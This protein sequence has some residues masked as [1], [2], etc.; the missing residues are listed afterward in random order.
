MF[1]N[2]FGRLFKKRKERQQREKLRKALEPTR[3]RLD[4]M[5]RSL[6]GRQDRLGVL[7]AKVGV[8][9][10]QV[11]EHKKIA[12]QELEKEFPDPKK[13]NGAES[14]FEEAISDFENALKAYQKYF[15]AESRYEGE[16]RDWSQLK[17]MVEAAIKVT[18]IDLDW[19]REEK[20][21]RGL[22]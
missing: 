16:M 1:K 22:N 7:G 15:K 19:I 18:Q 4:R 20:R 6:F 21:N 9:L 12:A 8:L 2:P 3:R 5:S 14:L 13:I 17:K 10:P 11:E